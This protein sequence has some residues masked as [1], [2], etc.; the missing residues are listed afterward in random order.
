MSTTQTSHEPTPD[1]L[2]HAGA[3]LGHHPGDVVDE[4]HGADDHGEDHGHDDHAHGDEDALGPIDVERWG[5]LGLGL[6]A[7]LL[8]AICL[9]I[10]ANLSTTV[11]G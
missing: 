4:A 9:L 1:E 7:G 11:A 3:D 6:A 2:D 10:T 8:V 5:A